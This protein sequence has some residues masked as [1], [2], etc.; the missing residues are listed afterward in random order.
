M[1]KMRDRRMGERHSEE[2]TKKEIEIFGE[3]RVFDDS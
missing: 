3:E 2:S 1:R